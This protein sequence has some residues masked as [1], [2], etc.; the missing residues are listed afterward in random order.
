MFGCV[1]GVVVYVW[2][3]CLYMYMCECVSFV[4]ALKSDNGQC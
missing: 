3:V 2:R 1:D 4:H